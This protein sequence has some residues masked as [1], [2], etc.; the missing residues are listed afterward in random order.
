MSADFT[1]SDRLRAV[2]GYVEPGASVIDVGTDHAYVPIWLLLNEIC[3][4]AYASDLRAGPLSRAEN[5]ARYWGVADRLT[6]LLCDGLS[7]CVPEALDTVILAG[8]GGETIRAIL[9]ASP[10]ALKKRLILQPQTHPAEL[11]RWLAKRGVG[12]ADVTLAADAGRIYDVWLALP[13]AVPSCA[14]V[15]PSLPEKRDP[16]LRPWLEERLRRGERKRFGMERAKCPDEAA[17]A[18][19]RQELDALRQALAALG[20]QSG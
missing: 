16:L 6:L 17:L 5:D 9:E 3:S 2:A 15:H 11:E 19:L 7:A 13:D 8:M 18:A 20:A 14:P 1:L 12:I 4:T 10:W